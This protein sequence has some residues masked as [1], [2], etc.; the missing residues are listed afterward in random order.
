L[1]T[2]IS[3]LLEAEEVEARS[4][5]DVSEVLDVIE[6]LPK[7]FLFHCRQGRHI[8]VEAN[9]DENVEHSGVRDVRHGEELIDEVH[10]LYDRVAGVHIVF[11]AFHCECREVLQ[12]DRG[13]WVF[14]NETIIAVI[15]GE[16]TRQARQR[17]HA[18]D[19]L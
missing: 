9:S 19:V 7:H 12:D 2:R 17:V 10:D 6:M 11:R 16:R 4:K 18:T 14:D 15:E 1:K 3:G 8:N 5:E 13:T